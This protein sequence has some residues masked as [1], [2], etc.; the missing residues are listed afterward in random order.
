LADK[1]TNNP[2]AYEQYLKGW[3]NS[4]QYTNE[5][6]ARAKFHLEKAIELDPEFS[7][8]YAALAILYWR[9]STTVGLW[10]GLGIT[11]KEGTIHAGLK[12]RSLLENQRPSLRG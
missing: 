2:L 9:A 11:D 5:S 3:E 7:R 4:R 12:Y 10:R 6:F 8:A 1:G